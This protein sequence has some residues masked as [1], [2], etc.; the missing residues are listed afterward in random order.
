[1]PINPKLKAQLEADK[2]MT[3]DYRAK[4]IATLD[5]APPSVQN[6]WMS[7]SDYTRQVNEFKET[8]TEWKTRADKFH[9]DTEKA[10]EAWKA[11][12]ASANTAVEQARARIAELEAGGTGTGTGAGIPKVPDEAVIK[13]LNGLKTLISSIEGKIGTAVTKEDLNGAYTSAVSFI[14]QQVFDMDE[15]SARHQETFGVRFDKEKRAAL[16]DFANKKSAELGH[17]V[18]LDDAYTMQMGDDLKKKEREKIEAEAIEKYKTHHSVPGGG[19]DVSGGAGNER[20]PAQIRLEQEQNRRA[21]VT[22]ASKIGHATW[23]EA[24]A[25]AAQELVAEGKH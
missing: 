6:N 5:D 1:M 2:T 8:Q 24:A 20:G 9:S 21:G 22:D 18:S 13:E 23:Q 3:D 7:Q 17:R 19:D 25:A 15:I 10:V 12:V 16:I 4:L 14:G 11:E